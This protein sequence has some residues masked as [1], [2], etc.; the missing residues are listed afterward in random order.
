MG[1]HAVEGRCG[2]LGEL[3]RAVAGWQQDHCRSW[4]RHL[5]TLILTTHPNVHFV[6]TRWAP[7]LGSPARATLSAQQPP[8]WSRF[9]PWRAGPTPIASWRQS[10]SRRNRRYPTGGGPP[11]GSPRAPGTR[12]RFGMTDC[13]LVVAQL[14]LELSAPASSGSLFARCS[15]RSTPSCQA[16]TP[17]AR[18]AWAMCGCQRRVIV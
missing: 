17:R 14:V 4:T 6:V 2:R 7:V 1:H 10:F 9:S 16:A 12:P 11:T 3:H 13:S 18:S 8:V 5:A 15:V